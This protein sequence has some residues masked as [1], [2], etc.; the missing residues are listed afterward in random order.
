M[1]TKTH[2]QY[3][4]QP[5]RKTG[6]LARMV[7]KLATKPEIK[8]SSTLDW[9]VAKIAARPAARRE[10][11]VE[12]SKVYLVGSGI[13][14]V[15]TQEGRDR[16]LQGIVFAGKERYGLVA[17]MSAKQNQGPDKFLLTSIGEGQQSGVVL[18]TVDFAELRQ[19]RADGIVQNWEMMRFGRGQN[20]DVVISDDESVSRKHFTMDIT[21]SD[22][23]ISDENSTNGTT[24]ITVHMAE[25][26]PVLAGLWEAMNANPALWS[27]E[28]KGGTV[29]LPQ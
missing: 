21:Q 15:K 26:T 14:R 9:E 22:V 17:E 3:P 5:E 11:G 7:G 18:R 20:N 1:K 25:T 24:Y 6:R 27:G 12:A 8:A 13:A 10:Q 4:S 19:P 2:N 28:Y 16:V 29:I 23:R